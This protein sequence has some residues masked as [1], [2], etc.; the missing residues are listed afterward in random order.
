M[1]KTIIEEDAKMSEEMENRVDSSLIPF[2]SSKKF[3]TAYRLK[4]NLSREDSIDRSNPIAHSSLVKDFFFHSFE[5]EN[6][7]I[8]LFDSHALITLKT[9]EDAREALSHSGRLHQGKKVHIEL[10]K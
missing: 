5:L 10:L 8:E 9:L 7:S 3:K 2:S 1:I 4:V 6:E